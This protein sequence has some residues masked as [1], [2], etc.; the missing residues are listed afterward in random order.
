MPTLYYRRCRYDLIQVFQIIR[1]IDHIISDYFSD[2]NLGITRNNHIYKL[3]K[4]R[5]NSTHK[6]HGFS[7]IIINDWNGLPNSVGKVNTKNAFKS[8]L[9]DNRKDA[10]LKCNFKF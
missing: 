10:D 5:S 9:E 2:L 6:I 8:L 3:H 7:Y 4:P 1:Q